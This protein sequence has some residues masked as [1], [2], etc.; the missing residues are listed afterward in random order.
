MWVRGNS[1]DKRVGARRTNESAAYDRAS[2]DSNWVLQY[3]EWYHFMDGDAA[4]F[5]AKSTL[6]NSKKADQL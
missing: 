2:A 6:M 3:L 4:A 1:D 5:D